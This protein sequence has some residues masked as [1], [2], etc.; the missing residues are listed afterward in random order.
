MKFHFTAS[1]HEQA[2]ARFDHMTTR[3][4]QHALGDC[5][6]II[7]LGGDGQMLNALRQNLAYG[8]DIFG[9]NFDPSLIPTSLFGL[10]I[11]IELSNFC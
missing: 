9:I 7:V 2:Q 5:D 1:S 10:M 11:V 4:G 3:Y 8:H 6:V